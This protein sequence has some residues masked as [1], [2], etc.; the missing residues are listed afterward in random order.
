MYLSD[1]ISGEGIIQVVFLIML[2][3]QILKGGPRGVRWQ[4]LA[5]GSPWHSAYGASPGLAEGAG[6]CLSQPLSVADSRAMSCL[7]STQGVARARWPPS[8]LSAA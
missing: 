2:I 8:F 5:Q 1:G 4:V 6:L 7:P 3:V